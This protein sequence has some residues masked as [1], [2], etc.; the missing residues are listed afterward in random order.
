MWS[1]GLSNAIRHIVN[2]PKA[3]REY[4]E[5]KGI[6]SNCE[7][8]IRVYEDGDTV[9][10][11]ED[12]D[13]LLTTD[14]A[15]IKDVAEELGLLNTSKVNVTVCFDYPDSRNSWT[16]LARVIQVTKMDSN[17]IYGIELTRGGDKTGS[18][19]KYDLIKIYGDIELSG[20][21]VQE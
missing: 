13:H 15:T 20:F 9:E 19:K 16:I 18:F 5:I 11:Y 4:V 3:P 14:K 21:D 10:F 8:K 2:P 17:F 1:S 12:N 7:Q 6:E